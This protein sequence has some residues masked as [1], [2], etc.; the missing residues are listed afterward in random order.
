MDLLETKIIKNTGGIGKY[1]E[2]MS[3]HFDVRGWRARWN[4]YSRS[5]GSK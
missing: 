5:E 3:I 4:S 2:T 1:V